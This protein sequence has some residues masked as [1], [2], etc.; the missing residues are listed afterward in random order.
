MILM[1]EQDIPDLNI[2]M[3]CDNLNKRAL[4]KLPH[5][6]YIRTCKSEELKIWMEFPFDNL[7]YVE[8]PEIFDESAK[9]SKINQF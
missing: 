9:S 8:A 4:S 6:F 5:G 7:Q 2:F 1:R 3:M